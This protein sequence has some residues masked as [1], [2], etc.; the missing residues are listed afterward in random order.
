MELNVALENI[1]VMKRGHFPFEEI[2]TIRQ[3][4][5]DS[6]PI[7][8]Q[9]VKDQLELDWDKFNNEDFSADARDFFAMY[10][11]AEHK[12][13]EA[14]QYLIRYLEFEDSKIVDFLL[15]D[16][17]TEGFAGVLASVATKNDVE[18]V[19]KA[20]ENDKLFEFSRSAAVTTL[21]MMYMRGFI[22]YKEIDS[23]LFEQMEINKDDMDF[24]TLLVSECVDL[25][26]ESC[27]S[28]LEQYFA[29]DR[30]DERFADLDWYQKKIANSSIE[31][32]LEELKNSP[33]NRIVTP[34]VTNDISHWW[35]FAK[36][37]WRKELGRKIGRNEMC[38]C[39][40]GK[41][42]KKCCG[43]E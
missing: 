26:L 41:K 42:Y 28:K 18:R 39:G 31:S 16:D 7:L 12:E 20:I 13:T 6:K 19:K 35:W 40:S 27:F 22:T 4:W 10:L 34:E 17:L 25:H 36:P 3:N 15:G 21:G 38:P 9:Y 24:L 2:E 37:G 23:Y 1:K 11:L 14:F 8:L 5:D 30:L 43:G 29:E 32:A 33:H